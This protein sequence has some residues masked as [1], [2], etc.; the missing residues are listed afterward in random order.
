MAGPN[1]EVEFYGHQIK[2]LASGTFGLP[3]ALTLHFQSYVDKMTLVVT[4]DPNVISDPDRV[5]DDIKD[6][7]LMFTDVVVARGLVKN[8][9]Y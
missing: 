3:Q 4:T 6:A 2:F 7:L 5:C 1:Q 8:V 9:K